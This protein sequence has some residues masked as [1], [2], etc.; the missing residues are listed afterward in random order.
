[1]VPFLELADGKT[2]ATGEGADLIEP[3]A[4]GKSLK[5]TW[6][7]WARIGAKSGET[8]PNGLASE[9]EFRLAANR[10][11]RRETLTADQDV[12]IKNW[13]VAVPASADRVRSEP[14]AGAAVYYLSGREG[15]LA[16]RVVTGWKTAAETVAT[17]DTRLGKGVLG[18]I[19]FH[20]VFQSA[21]MTLKRGKKLTWEMSLELI[22]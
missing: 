18:A 20:L 16:V 1:M 4:D 3:A 21:E 11:V 22:K 5:I 15:T 9:V 7:K 12:V 13:R 8:F 17:G 19:P 10:L 14:S 2:Y 6:R